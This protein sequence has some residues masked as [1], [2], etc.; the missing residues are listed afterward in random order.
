MKKMPKEDKE[1]LEIQRKTRLKETLESLNNLVEKMD[2]KK[3]EMLE[4]ARS[5][6]ARGSQTSLNLAKVGLANALSTRKRAEEMLLQ[7]DIMSSMRDITELTK[8]FLSVVQDTCGDIMAFSKDNNFNKVSKEM[9]K[10]FNAVNEQSDGLARLMEGSS[11]SLDALNFNF[12]NELQDEVNALIEGQAAASENA[13]DD[14][15]SA[16]IERLKR[17]E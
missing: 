3:E 9:E 6:M 4:K 10:A 14:E 8:G 15:I 13:M 16:K 11:L 5:A 7:L 2:R 1:M 17:T 12:S